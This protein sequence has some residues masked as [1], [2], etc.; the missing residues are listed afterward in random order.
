MLLLLSLLLYIPKILF[1]FWLAHTVWHDPS[2]Q[3][4]WFKLFL[5]IPLGL[6]L[7]S[8]GY[9]LWIWAGLSRFIFPWLELVVSLVFA[10]LA[11]LT[12]ISLSVPWSF[13]SLKSPLNLVFLLTILVFVTLFGLGLYMNPHGAE[14]A[15]F[16]WNLDSRFIYLAQDFR[17]L[18]ASSGPGW[19]P[20]YPLM[21]SLNIVSGWVV[22]GQ[23]NSRIQMAVT[24]L[25]TLALPGILFFGLALVKDA[26]QA[27]LATLVILSSPMIIDYGI[28]QQADIP[29]AGFVLASLVLAALFFRTREAN[30]LFLAGL[31]TSLTAWVKNEGFLFVSVSAVLIVVFLAA[32]KQIRFIKNYTV[33]VGIPLLVILLYKFS[34]PVGNDL[35]VKNDLAQLLEWDRYVLILNSLFNGLVNLGGWP[36]FSLFAI[37]FIYLMLVW[38]DYPDHVILRFVGLVLL[39]QLFGYFVIYLLTPHDLIWHLNTSFGRLL[40]QLFPSGLFLFFYAAKSPDFNLSEGWKNASHN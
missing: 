11:F 36:S 38:F 32:L 7:W 22:L 13:R 16:I 35:F 15:W 28:S 17:I 18:Y 5:G 30:L 21:V 14:D 20:D 2:P 8:L 4:L 19:H 34:L 23:D 3:A 29:V 31:T 37:L 6:G 1:G 10:V 12:L 26:R 25:F 9:F 33:G 39:A 24:T 40:L 27:T